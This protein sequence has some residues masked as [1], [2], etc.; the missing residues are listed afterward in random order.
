MILGIVPLNLR[1]C[2]FSSS[3][4]HVQTSNTCSDFGRPP[5]GSEVITVLAPICSSCRDL[6][7]P[8]S[9]SHFKVG[10][11]QITNFCREL[12]RPFLG[13]DTRAGQL[14]ICNT[15]RELGR[16]FLG[17]HQGRAAMRHLIQSPPLI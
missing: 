14:E 10:Q 15:C 13:R 12:G 2:L 1:H 8:S 11:F 9:G 4:S 16:P 7:R 17:R 5:L 6:G 3:L